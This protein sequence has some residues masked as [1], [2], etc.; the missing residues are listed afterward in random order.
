MGTKALP[1]IYICGF[2]KTTVT[3]EKLLYLKTKQKY[4]GKHHLQA[5]YC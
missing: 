4:V 3:L 1:V 2:A 5:N